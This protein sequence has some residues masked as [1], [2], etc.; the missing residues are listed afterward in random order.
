MKTEVGQDAAG[1]L[2]DDVWSL[3]YMAPGVLLPCHSCLLHTKA[4]ASATRLAPWHVANKQGFSH[5]SWKASCREPV[6]LFC[7]VVD[8]MNHR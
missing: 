1:K 4:E 7:K 3:Q 6:R 2:L 8:D 5:V